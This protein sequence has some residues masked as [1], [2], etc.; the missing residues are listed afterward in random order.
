MLEIGKEYRVEH[1]RKGVFKMRITSEYE[2]W[3]T[4]VLTEGRIRS[5]AGWREVGEEI[6]VRKSFANFEMI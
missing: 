5:R 1:R 2:T 6:T 4:G 3:V